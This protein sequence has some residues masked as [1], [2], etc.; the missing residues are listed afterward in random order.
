MRIRNLDSLRGIAALT[1]VFC[2]CYGLYPEAIRFDIHPTNLSAWTEPWAWLRYTPL[3]LFVN[4]EAAV[5]VF[6]VLSGYV[7]TLPFIAGTQPT[8]GRYLLKRFCRIYLPF[9]AAILVAAAL[10]WLVNPVPISALSKQ[11][12]VGWW[13]REIGGAD[14]LRHLS[15]TGLERDRILDPPMWSLVHEMRISIIFPLL[16]F[17]FLRFGSIAAITAALVFSCACTFALVIVGEQSAVGTIM[18]TG[19]MVIY[20]GAGIALAI[21]SPARSALFSGRSMPVKV[22]LWGLCAALLMAPGSWLP[23]VN[24]SWGAGAVLLVCL[25][26]SARRFGLLLS[27]PGCQWLGRVSY[28]LYLFHAIVLLTA[29]HLLY[30]RLPL[31]VIWLGVTA[32]SL[33]CAQV[34]FR[35][36]ELPSI[37][38]GRM[39]QRESVVVAAA[40]D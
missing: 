31:T 4:G 22:I 26:L 27:G 16:V 17:F 19:Q 6:F 7:L 38:L 1:V 23:W 8:Y 5:I 36:I 21:N 24:L 37:R 33:L 35:L 29:V 14:V 25:S 3:R 15:M 10:I 12:N 9:A 20:F 13:D 40:G 34:A 11:F 30:G 39:T 2:H 18:A 28:S 32:V